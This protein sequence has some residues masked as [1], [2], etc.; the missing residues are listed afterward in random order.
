[1]SETQEAPELVVFDLG[2]LR[3]LRDDQWGK[4]EGAM[5]RLVTGGMGEALD[6]ILKEGVRE[7]HVVCD[8]NGTCHGVFTDKAY[9]VVLAGQVDGYLSTHHVDVEQEP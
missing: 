6:L 2:K 4:S 3:A 1:M 5:S 9:A 8:A 7:L